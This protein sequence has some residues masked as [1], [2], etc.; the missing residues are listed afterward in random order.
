M[1]QPER[2]SVSEPP[3]ET[4]PNEPVGPRDVTRP[5]SRA[6]PPRIEPSADWPSGA[7]AHVERPEVSPATQ[8][9]LAVHLI[10]EGVL[11]VVTAVF[12][13]VALA[14]TAGAQVADIVRPV[15]Y[16]GLV[17][18]GL[19]LSLRTGTPNLAVGSIA[20]ATG[21]VGAHLAGT[22]G[23]SLW[24]A[25]AV[26]VAM[27]VAAGVVA[28]LIVAGLSVPAW[29]VTL[30]VALLVQAAAVRISSG[31]PVVL[32]GAGSYPAALWLAAFAAVSI[33]GGAL[34]QIS[35]VRTA[36]SA[37][38]TTGDPGRWAG[39]PAGLGALAGLTGSSLLA[40]I[41]GV[42]LAVYLQVGDPLSGGISLT[43]IAFAAVLVGGV[44]VFGRRAGVLGTVLGVVIAQTTVFLLD[45][46]AVPPYWLDVA[47]GVMALLGLGVNRALESIT[48]ALSRQRAGQPA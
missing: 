2:A 44:S 16:I 30:A 42:S 33:G 40:G 39:L 48:N 17:A 5:W 8:D 37:A 27:A 13:G 4:R 31:Q 25:M 10:W 19:G 36:L 22:D 3:E 26:A 14:S 18:A 20:T 15:G 1:P 43:L 23:W 47:I 35:A 32:H 46:H 45:V 28:G 38:R 21:V 9:R 6:R 11:L 41:G 7:Q 12:V 24:A 29:A 34:W